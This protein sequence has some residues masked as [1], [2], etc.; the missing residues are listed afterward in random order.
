MA[1]M[2]K[3]RRRELPTVP[4]AVES[5]PQWLAHVNRVTALTAALAATRAGLTD[6]EQERIRI[7]TT[8]SEDS[9]LELLAEDPAAGA[10]LAAGKRRLTEI[11]ARLID[12][13]ERERIQAEGITR[14]EERSD[15][16]RAEII[17]EI[18]RDVVATYK[19]LSE[20][21]GAQL[22]ALV[23]INQRLFELQQQHGQVPSGE[24]LRGAIWWF[25]LLPGPARTKLACWIEHARAL[26]I[27]VS[28]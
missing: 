21:L 9:V 14:L 4:P 23:P 27:P 6:L 2:T 8:V 7:S 5:H 17:P 24:G 1:L 12:A 16:I 11:D 28:F 22:A 25:E 3:L 10:R 20:L 13:R 18:Q 19:Q 26:G 15:A